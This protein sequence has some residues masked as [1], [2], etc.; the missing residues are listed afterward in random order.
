[1]RSKFRSLK[2]KLTNDTLQ[3]IR[4]GLLPCLRSLSFHISCSAHNG[5]VDAMRI[6][7]FLR[8]SHSNS[9]TLLSI[10][11]LVYMTSENPSYFVYVYSGWTILDTAIANP[12]FPL[13]KSVNI[14][15]ISPGLTNGP[16]L[17]VVDENR[18]DLEVRDISH[19]VMARFPRTAARGCGAPTI[20]VKLLMPDCMAATDGQRICL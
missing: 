16:E 13:L 10:D 7:S 8:S 2:P 12:K 4:I 1:M 18:G 9:L 14:R 5:W 17:G 3:C 11:I 15:L 20:G 6:F 19:L